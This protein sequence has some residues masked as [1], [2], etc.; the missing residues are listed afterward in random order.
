MRTETVFTEPQ[1]LS[2]PWYL[3]TA[4]WCV[5]VP[6]L[7]EEESQA[8][9]GWVMGQVAWRSTGTV[10]SLLRMAPILPTDLSPLPDLP[11]SSGIFIIFHWSNPKSVD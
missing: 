7:M 9:R 8:Q 3:R 10:V 11:V 1:G 5:M 6:Y 4:L 2:T